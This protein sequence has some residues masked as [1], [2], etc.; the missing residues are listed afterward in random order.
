VTRTNAILVGQII[1]VKAGTDLTPF[2]DAANH[3]VDAVCLVVPVGGITYTEDQLTRI[4][5][6]LAAHHYA[7]LDPRSERERISTLT[8]QIETKV[9]LGLD[10][11][12]YGQMAMR[13]DVN[14]G[15]AAMNNAMKKQT[16]Q[17]PSAGTTLVGGVKWLG[18]PFC[19]E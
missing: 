1:K 3:L 14:G 17:L 5:T 7:I 13:L 9:D 12:R 10:V 19:E 18:T 4:E 6:W 2:I 11:T 16:K 8:K 15:L